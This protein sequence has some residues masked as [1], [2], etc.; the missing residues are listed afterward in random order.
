[1]YF[2][3]IDVKPLKEYKLL[4]K[5]ENNEERIFDVSPFLNIGKF[6]ELKN[7]SLFNSVKVNFDS[8]EWANKV[9]LDPEFLYEK[10][11]KI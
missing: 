7:E 11:V 3:V 2:S 5:F 1:M 10:S 9:D 8:V 4:V 6:S